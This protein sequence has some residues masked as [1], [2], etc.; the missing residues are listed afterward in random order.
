MGG[1]G[2][3]LHVSI[4]VK[5]MQISEESYYSKNSFFPTFFL[6]YSSTVLLWRQ[7][8]YACRCLWTS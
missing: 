3:K 1:S 8:I 5:L 2:F 7:I 4:S 6:H